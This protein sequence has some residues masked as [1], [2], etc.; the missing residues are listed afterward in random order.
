MEFFIYFYFH[1]GVITKQNLKKKEEKKQ[2]TLHRKK[3]SVCDSNA[4]F[5]F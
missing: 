1:I 3:F 5:F 4:S 2:P